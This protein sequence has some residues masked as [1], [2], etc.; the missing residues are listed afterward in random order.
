MTFEHGI[1]G[2]LQHFFVLIVMSRLACRL[3]VR[4][5]LPIFRMTPSFA[6]LKNGWAVSGSLRLFIIASLHV[7]L[8]RE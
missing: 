5:A 7:L 3:G 2:F 6:S 1:H 8:R 4:I